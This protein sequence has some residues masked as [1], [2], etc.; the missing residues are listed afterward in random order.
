MNSDDSSSRSHKRRA[1]A[2]FFCCCST[3]SNN[4]EPN[5]RVV[6]ITAGVIAIIAMLVSGIGFSSLQRATVNPYEHLFITDSSSRH[7]APVAWGMPSASAP[8]SQPTLPPSGGFA[9]A[10]GSSQGSPYEAPLS[11]Q[12]RVSPEAQPAVPVGRFSNAATAPSPLQS[13]HTTGDRNDSSAITPASGT[14]QGAAS[15][16]SQGTASVEGAAS[17]ADSLSSPAPSPVRLSNSSGG[18]ISG[19]QDHRIHGTLQSAVS[20]LAVQYQKSSCAGNQVQLLQN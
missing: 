15:Q 8:L 2:G 12:A 10:E 18:S 13:V 16:A 6:R 19:T 7:L 1:I 14:S 9:S 4:L 5:S 3:P 20:L 17:D 11:D